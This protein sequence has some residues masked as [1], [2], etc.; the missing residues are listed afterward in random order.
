M[1][2]VAE[3]TSA[4]STASLTDDAAPG[5]HR[6]EH[7]VA[8]GLP[9]ASS[10]STP[11]KRVAARFHSETVPSDS[12]AMMALLV[13]WTRRWRSS[14]T[15]STERRARPIFHTAVANTRATTRPTT[16]TATGVARENID[17]QPP[18]GTAATSHVPLG[19]S[20]ERIAG[21]AEK[22]PASPT[23]TSPSAPRASRPLTAYS[24][25]RAAGT[26]SPASAAISSKLI[27]TVAKPQNSSPP[28][29]VGR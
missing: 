20:T 22:T 13:E 9:S 15:C 17:G 11:V 5:S 21:S 26:S 24:K 19:T 18:T 7:N 25:P 1:S 10:R 4:A 14:E 28:P 27:T 8:K 12:T 3:P 2:S 16:N 23:N 6:L 29:S